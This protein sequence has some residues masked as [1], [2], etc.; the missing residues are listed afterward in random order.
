MPRRALV[1]IT[2]LVLALHWLVL[3][4]VPLHWDSPAQAT[5]RAFSTRSIAAP[6][7]PALP[8][9]ATAPAAH[10]ARAAALQ[11]ADRKKPQARTTP[12]PSTMAGHAAPQ[13]PAETMTTGPDAGT[14][15]VPTATEPIAP[16]T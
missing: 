14:D 7:P 2:A 5:G 10:T 3:S 8:T 11:P 9:V 16:P 13:L 12:A 1:A 15:A 6:L 4:G